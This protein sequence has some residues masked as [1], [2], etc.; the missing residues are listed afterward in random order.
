MSNQYSPAVLPAGPRKLLLIDHQ[1]AARNSKRRSGRTGGVVRIVVE[2]ETGPA[3]IVHARGATCLGAAH[4]EY[5]QHG[6]VTGSAR[7]ALVTTGAV[8]I[9]GGSSE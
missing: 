4:I 8:E 1:A 6:F 7:V 9:D 3:Q 5:H 2:D